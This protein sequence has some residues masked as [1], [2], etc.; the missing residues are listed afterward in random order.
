ML[1]LASLNS[2]NEKW[3][4]STSAVESKFINSY[5]KLNENGDF[6]SQLEEAEN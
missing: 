3:T 2:F 5:V 1:F 4:C 6:K